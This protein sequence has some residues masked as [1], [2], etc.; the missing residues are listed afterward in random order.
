MIKRIFIK[1][2]PS[3]QTLEINVQDGFN[4]IS[5]V[6]GAGKSVFFDSILGM[7]GLKESNAEVLE[8]D[9][10][11]QT[12]NICNI[13]EEFG[14]NIE[15]EQNY[16]VI[17]VLKKQ[18][19]RY[20]FNHQALSKKKLNQ[21][22][23]KF[24]KYIS[25]KDGDELDSN[26]ILD[27]LDSLIMQH[28][29]DFAKILQ[30]FNAKF[31]QYKQCNNKLKE[32]D[33]MQRNIA[34]LKEFAIFEID[35]IRK[36]NPQIGEYDKLLND[37]KLLSKKEKMIDSCNQ[38]LVILDSLDSVYKTLTLLEIPSTDF[39]SS[40]LEVRASIENALTEFERLDMQ[41][42]VL[43]ERLSELAEINRRYGSEELAIKQ[44][45]A[46][47]LKLKEYENIDFNKSQLERQIQEIH[48]ELQAFSVKIT[49]QRHIFLTDFTQRFNSFATQLNL[50]TINFHI[51]E[52]VFY[53]KGKDIVLLLLDSKEKEVLSS[54]EYNRLRL[55]MLCMMIECGMQDSGILLLDEIDANLSGEESEGVAK[56]LQF[57]SK[58]YQIFAISHQPF[59][60]LMSDQH[61]LISK[62]FN[63]YSHIELLDTE[64]KIREIARMIGGSNLDSHALDYA[65]NLLKK[66]GVKKK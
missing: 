32:I 27:T 6:S 22:T 41:P 56:L 44:L 57:L 40:I 30:Q 59:M 48:Q 63:N 35:K 49:E 21:I 31:L 38:S 7:F 45:E 66:K 1:N 24:V 3:F 14:I 64:S 20:F 62:D 33:E 11:I 10:E 18:N 43:L 34:N 13:L 8:V 39:E 19:T 50:S 15:N 2:S 60:P 42:E 46:Q 25:I 4:V 61:Y 65:R 54:G 36:I 17:S 52:T 26:N 55:C 58:T 37:K 51:K 5:G 9:I 47:Q 53:E 16:Q 29:K 23:T 12:Q 28:N